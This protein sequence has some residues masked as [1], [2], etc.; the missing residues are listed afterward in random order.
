MDKPQEECGVLGI[1]SQEPLDI[2]GLLHLGLLA[3]QHRGQEAA[4]MAVSD[5]KGFLVE[6]DLGLVNQV[7][8]EER[9][10]R[11]RL[12]EARLGLAHTRYSTTGSNLRFNAQPLT[13]RTAHGV[14]AIAHNGNFTNAKPLRDR[15]LRE[16]ATFQ[17]TSDT[18]VML[19][20]LARL[21]HLSLPE[22]AAEA[23]KALEGG[24][25]ILLMDRRT[26]V[27]LRDPHG[28][29][30]L[31]IGRLPK[32]YAFASEPPALELMGARYIR[33]VR[34][35]EVVWVEEGE[36]KS[37]QALPPSPA[38]CAFEWIYFARPDSLLDGLEA[39]E[40][41]VRMGMEL[42]REAPAEADM[43]V[44]VP[45]SG[46]GAAVGYA[47]SSGLPLEYGLYKN[48]YAGRTFI[49]PTQALR[50]LKTRLK[51][52][53][54]SAVRGKRVVLID[55]SIVRGTTSRHIVAML[56]EAGALEVHF[57]VSSPPIR[58]PCYYGIDT[59]ARK[60]LIAAE[61][62]VEEIRAFI[63][64]DTLAFLSEE[65]VRRAIG[66]PVCLACFNGRYPA[67]VPVEGEKLALEIL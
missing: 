5:G 38:P 15:L 64:A 42:F 43:V 34:P 2:P 12:P 30:P 31:A 37:L 27:A 57:R 54:T 19:L 47:R 59:A 49:Q 22:A 14:L 36:L 1:Y 51:L 52:S 4:G 32:G 44:P 58:F 13:A 61:K 26:V 21:G 8:T 35:G 10:S 18:E 17:S 53:P 46:I 50:D 9:L 39:Y 7:F 29:R 56:R 3:L 20:L 67:G 25:S 41:R 24:Y 45:D 62:S 55:D 40:A 66:G 60:E 33:D 6:K 16:G 28:V 65:G 48:P 11:L 23:M 63:G